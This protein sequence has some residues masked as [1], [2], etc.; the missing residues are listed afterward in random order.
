MGTNGGHEHTEASAGIPGD[1]QII[2]ELEPDRAAV[3]T[4]LTLNLPGRDGAPHPVSF[5]VPAGVSDG[6]LLKVP[7]RAGPGVPGSATEVFYVRVRVTG[8]TTPDATSPLAPPTAPASPMTASWIS[9]RNG[10]EGRGRRWRALGLGALLV[11]AAG[12]VAL[13]A[14]GGG[15]TADGT[16]ASTG[17]S[18]LQSGDRTPSPTVTPALTLAEYTQTVNQAE[19]SLAQGFGRLRA[20]RTPAA[21]SSAAMTLGAS[22]RRESDALRS[23]LPP[24]QVKAAHEALFPALNALGSDVEALVGL[25]DERAVCA[26]P[27]ATATAARSDG[28][29]QLRKALSA[30]KAAASSTAFRIGSSLPEAAPLP[31]RRLANGTSIRSAK[32][33]RGQLTVENGGKADAVVTLSPSGT[34]TATVQ[35]Y[36]RGSSTAKVTRIPDDVYDAYMTFGTDWDAASR[37]F[38]RT[39][40]FQRFD[41]TVHFQTTALT[42]STNRISITPVR[43]GNATVSDVDPDDFPT[44]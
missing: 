39:C 13:A 7:Q 18:R 4:V 25:A 42:Y 26:G 9:A 12:A 37:L 15:G 41:R 3:G 24:E 44:G 11:V 31:E 34:A 38:T 29:T 5:R 10:S 16:T 6:T 20:A 14:P 30:L 36:V 43:N 22:L 19:A 23:V 1:R 27:S 2:V 8:G 21:V 33:G 28:A 35:V 17:P 40:T 32:G